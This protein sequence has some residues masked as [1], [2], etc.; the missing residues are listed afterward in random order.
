[1]NST[2]HQLQREIA[3]SLQSLDATQTQLR[4]RPNKWTIQQII[5]HLQPLRPELHIAR[6]R[7]AYEFTQY[8]HLNVFPA[9]G[10][11]EFHGVVNSANNTRHLAE[12]AHANTAPGARY[13]GGPPCHLAPRVGAFATQPWE[14]E[15]P[16]EPAMGY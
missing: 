12:N 6:G 4:P 14:N 1:M 15:T 8:E 5:E 7:H 2:L 16:C 3:N 10:N 9:L 11:H 13:I